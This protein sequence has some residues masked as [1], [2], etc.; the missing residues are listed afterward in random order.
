MTGEQEILLRRYAESVTKAPP[1][2]HLTSD[3][4]MKIF[5]RRHVM[6]AIG[7]FTAIP[8]RYLKNTMKILDAGSGNGIPGIPAA[9]LYP[10]SS[11]DLVDSDSRKCGFLDMFC[12]SNMILNARVIV[13]R[14]ELLAHSDMRET[15]D[16]VFS[17]AL[18]K[19]PV[20]IE[21]SGAFAR[22]GGLLIVPHGTS[23]VQEI[24]KTKKA[25]EMLGLRFLEPKEY[26]IGDGKVSALMF[27]KVGSAAREF[28]RAAGIPAKRPL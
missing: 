27:E 15:F 10:S 14:L 23:W 28:P 9:I 18:A 21:L 22:I 6:D 16:L 11:V 7:L 1:H 12:K 2:L 24:E 25:T 20:A 8:P 3:R 19:L 17:R 4:D 26:L 5:W 13:G